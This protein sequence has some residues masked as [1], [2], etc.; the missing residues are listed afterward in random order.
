MRQ[1]RSI[2]V[3][4]IASIIAFSSLPAFV[5]AQTSYPA[6]APNTAYAVGAQVTYQDSTHPNH[7]YKCQQAHTSQVGWEPPNTPALWIDEGAYGGT[8]ATNTPTTVP[9]TGPSSTPRPTTVPTAT[10]TS[11]GSGGTCATP[12]VQGNVYTGGMIVSY[13]G[14][15]WLAKWWTQNEYP[16]TGGSGVWQDNGPCSTDRKSVA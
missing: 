9:T 5:S 10:A 12:Y 11:S 8:S 7:L 6:W 16:S 2:L 1:L 3:P 4:I 15:N 13:Q 14:H